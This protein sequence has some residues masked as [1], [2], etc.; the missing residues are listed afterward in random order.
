[1]DSTVPFFVC[2]EM[3]YVPFIL[4]SK[5]MLINFLLEWGWGRVSVQ[6]FL[7]NCLSFFK[8][9]LKNFIILM[10]SD[11]M[12]EKHCCALSPPQRCSFQ[13]KK[14]KSTLLR[15]PLQANKMY[16]FEAHRSGRSQMH[17]PIWASPVWDTEY[18]HQ[19]ERFPQTHSQSAPLT[20]RAGRNG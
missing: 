14:K 1:M 15:Y 8:K 7:H 9:F 2:A 4:H 20:P 5:W 10:Q 17:T 11:Y 16:S 13:K 12:D 6:G 3:L 19:P 18:F